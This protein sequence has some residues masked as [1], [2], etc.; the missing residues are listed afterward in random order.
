MTAAVGPARLARSPRAWLATAWPWILIAAAY[1]GTRL[2]NLVVMP[3]FADEGAYLW[4]GRQLLLGDLSRGWGQGKP[5]S[6]WLVALPLALGADQ[7]L[8]TRLGCVLAGAVGL[9]AAAHLTASALSARAALAAAVLWVLLPYTLFFER[10][11]T[12][13]VLLG[14]LAVLALDLAWQALHAAR[15]RPGL[16]LA[17]GI[18]LV[19][20]ALAKLPVSLFFF[21]LPAGVLLLSPAARS[22]ARRVPS[23]AALL[24]LPP[25]LFAAGVLAVGAYRWSAG[26]R[27]IGFGFDEIL[28]KSA[29]GAQRGSLIANNLGALLSWA[30]TYLTWPVTLALATTWIAAW[31]GPPLARLLA[32]ASGLWLAIFVGVA[33]FWVP[34]Y[35]WPALPPLL[36]LL[37][38]GVAIVVERLAAWITRRAGQAQPRWI[39]PGLGGTLVLGLA[40]LTSPLDRAIVADPTAARLPAEDR[41]AYVTYFGSGYGMPEA[42]AY[43]S[44]ALAAGATSTQVVAL[45]INDEAR[46]RAYLPPVLWPRL[47]QVHIVGG[48]NQDGVQQMARLRAWLPDADL[49]YV[50]V[51]SGLQWGTTWQQAFPQ[52]V[53]DRQFPKPGGEDAVEVW[54]MSP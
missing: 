4:W 16:A 52:A 40:I 18:A 26:A 49:T 36:L 44:G 9:A 53:L 1:L 30:G 23:A 54:R 29:G 37:G 39:Y 31:F 2:S 48:I 17:A 41:Q 50:I 12:P 8:A 28:L 5:L 24:Y 38:W 34:R 6:G 19:A 10:L 45:T 25:L 32:G 43:L 35:V 42:A 51:A 33:G 22:R 14:C 13:D 15:P 11:S 20:A 27:P 21:G 3:L 7:V 47:R 46:L